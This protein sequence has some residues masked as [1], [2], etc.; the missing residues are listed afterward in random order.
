MKMKLHT[1]AV[2]DDKITKTANG[3]PSGAFK[4]SLVL[5]VID[6]VSNNAYDKGSW[7]VIRISHSQYDE[8]Y[9]GD[10]ILNQCCDYRGSVYRRTSKGF[11][12][13]NA[14]KNVQLRVRTRI[15]YQ[16]D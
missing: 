5:L 13:R 6:L 12:V 8:S 11:S 7:N 3:I 10:S 2:I 9:T 1:N 16:Q 15:E 4:T 14:E